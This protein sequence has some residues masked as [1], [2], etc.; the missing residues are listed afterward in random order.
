MRRPSVGRE[1]GGN[2]GAV[3]LCSSL[4]A[5][6]TTAFCG[7]I[8]FVG[9]AVPHLA[10]GFLQTGD[11]RRLVPAVGVLGAILALVA[12]TLARWGPTV[13]PLNATTALLGAPVVFWLLLR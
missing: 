2:P 7:P 1:F 6:A 10:A 3:V 9:V 11:R 12:D 13:L 4:L 5:G 8:A